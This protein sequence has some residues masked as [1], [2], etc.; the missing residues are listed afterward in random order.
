MSIDWTPLADLIETH[1]RF[2]VTTHVR[3]D[4]DALGSE[5]GMAGLLRQRGKDV[6]VVN[7]S[8]TPPRYDF[9]DERGTLFRQIHQSIQADELADRE[10]A[11]ILDLSTWNQLG[12][13]AGPIRA[14]TGPRVVIDHHVSQDDLGA[15]F[16]KDSGAEA[17]GM[18]VADAIRS[19]GGSFTPEVAT[20][21]LTAIAMDTGW[22]RH[23][24]TRPRTLRVVAEL[25]EA[26][27]QI[28]TIYRNLFERNTLG[29]LRLLGET[30]VDLHIGFEGK[31]AY[32]LITLE[33][34]ANAGAIPPDTEDLI[35]Y[36]IS[37]NGA[38]VGLL[39]I[40]QAR[41]GVK[42]SFRSRNGLDCSQLAGSLGG[43][44]HRAAAGV[45]LAES[46]TD[47]VPLVLEA[48][49]KALEADT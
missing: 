1:D 6:L 4:G 10:V 29:R 37:V 8:P 30:L 36:V 5:V 23:S 49:R 18:L 24:N 2:L 34:M 35:D 38:S 42:V 26:G 17:S 32:A 45:T 7:S 16:L 3:P 44:G 33:N 47:S 9:L 14:F 25:I 15:V 13:M 28:N 21:L 22:F 31:V 27:A 11:V 20:G 43:G 46:M 12:E 39:F 41:G 40:E 48:V 19:L